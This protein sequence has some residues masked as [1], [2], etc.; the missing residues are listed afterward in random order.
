[1]WR[2]RLFEEVVDRLFGEGVLRG[3]SH[4]CVG[5]EA[6]AVGTCA[7]L[8]PDDYVTSTHRGHGHFLA[9]GGDPR[10][11]MAEL[12]GKATGY[13]RGRG[14]SQHMACFEIGFL[15][16]NGITGGGIPV[17]TGAALA[18]QRRREERVVACFFGEGAAN[19]GVFH[20]SLNM[21][22]LWKLPAIYVCENNLYAMSTP[23][24]GALAG[25]GVAAR[26]AGYGVPGALVDGNDIFAV[27][28]AASEAAARARCGEGPTLIECR[29]YR[30]LGHSRGDRRV[31]RT[32]EEEAEW[33]ARDPIP[34][35]RDALLRSGEVTALEAERIREEVEL[36]IRDA[37]AFARESP[38]LPV[39]A[40]LEGVYA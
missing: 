29:T 25:P 40:A 16:S 6:T 33:R 1:M 7:A 28:A 15:G 17:A 31:Y 19:Q 36:E 24:G 22:A 32:R 20:E 39:E 3:T 23:V 11:L 37:V 26:A 18:L 2:I 4:L 13:S 5:Q 30:L 10:R 21:A 8:R 35:L 34:R 38:A 27:R 9:K 12:F 14:G